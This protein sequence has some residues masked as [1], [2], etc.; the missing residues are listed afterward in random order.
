MAITLHP[1]KGYL[2]ASCSATDKIIPPDAVLIQV[3]DLEVA[4]SS[5][6]TAKSHLP[7]FDRHMLWADLV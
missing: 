6:L 2:V 5:I 1:T 7:L 3:F 4:L